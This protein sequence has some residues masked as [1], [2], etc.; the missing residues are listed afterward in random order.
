MSR[1]YLK[2]IQSAFGDFAA[3]QARHADFGAH[4]SEPCRVFQTVIHGAAFG[5]L[6][7]E[8]LDAESW[9]IFHEM[10]RAGVVAARLSESAGAVVRRIE[11]ARLEATPTEFRE[12]LGWIEG[13]CWRAETVWRRTRSRMLQ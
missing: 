6:P 2:A 10:P 9:E 5:G 13:Q 12:I 3:V 11:L 1:P 7:W 8:D 4:D